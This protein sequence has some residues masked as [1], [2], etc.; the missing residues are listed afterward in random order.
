MQIIDSMFSNM[1]VG[2]VN[3]GTRS[4][5]HPPCVRHEMV[6]ALRRT[7]RIFFPIE[8]RVQSWPV[9]HLVAVA[10]V[11]T[12]VGWVGG[13]DGRLGLVATVL[14]GSCGHI[15]GRRAPPATAS[16]ERSRKEAHNP[17][18]HERSSPWL[19]PAQHH[20]KQKMRTKKEVRNVTMVFQESGICMK[21]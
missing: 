3:E 8:G 19:I 20:S 15:V 1:V 18:S 21:E 13:K 12:A 14:C 16:Y 9:D 7:F 4:H 17:P 6:V 5:N 2:S 11:A 10:E